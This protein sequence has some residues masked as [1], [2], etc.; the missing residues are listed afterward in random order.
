MSNTVDRPQ[1]E[2]E[3]RKR[4]LQL[5]YIAVLVIGF[6]FSVATGFIV[7]STDGEGA[8]AVPAWMLTL[9]EVAISPW[10]WLAVMLALMGWAV[11]WTLAYWRQ[12]DELARAAHERAWFWGGSAGKAVG[13]SAVLIASATPPLRD[14]TFPGVTPMELV[15]LG[16]FGVTMLMLIGYGVAWAII[17]WRAR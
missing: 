3:R 14:L 12:L 4:R 10:L 1:S 16:A 17:W 2:K 6:A 5:Q 15:A 7:G 8:N 11:V 13:L 9:R